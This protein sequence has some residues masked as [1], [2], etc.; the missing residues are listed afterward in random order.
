MREMWGEYW[1]FGQQR[2][3][4]RFLPRTRRSIT[5]PSAPPT[6]NAPSATSSTAYAAASPPSPT[7]H[8]IRRPRR[9]LP[10][11]PPL[12]LFNFVISNGDNP[13]L[14]TP[15]RFCTT[16]YAKPLFGS[17]A[18]DDDVMVDFPKSPPQRQSRRHRHLTADPRRNL[19]ATGSGRT[20]HVPTRRHRPQRPS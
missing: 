15:A 3:F 2:P 8:P 13:C 18:F 16:S 10:T 14:P 19:V 6:P 5:M 1:L 9:T 20:G 11:N 12:G 7:R 4:N 17:T